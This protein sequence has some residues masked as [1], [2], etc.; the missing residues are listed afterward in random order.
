MHTHA[1]LA[2]LTHP[3]TTPPLSPQFMYC[4]KMCALLHSGIATPK[5][6]VVVFD[7]DEAPRY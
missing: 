3:Q 1:L 7:V 2:S 5:G 4:T 6:N